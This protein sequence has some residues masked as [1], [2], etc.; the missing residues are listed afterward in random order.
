MCACELRALC[1]HFRVV[2]CKQHIIFNKSAINQSHCT[3]E[4]GLYTSDSSNYNSGLDT[5]HTTTTTTQKKLIKTSN[6]SI[7]CARTSATVRAETGGAH[8]PKPKQE[9]AAQ[10]ARSHAMCIANEINSHVIH[11]VVDRPTTHA[12]AHAHA[13]AQTNDARQRTRAMRFDR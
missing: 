2:A 8:A 5:T 11:A 3:K 6:I 12:H 4:P 7:I 9:F 1:R 10:F 13:Q